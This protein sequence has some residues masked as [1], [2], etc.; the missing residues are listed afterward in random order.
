MLV[1]I[2]TPG[3][4]AASDQIEQLCVRE[5]ADLSILHA[6]QTKKYGSVLC[7]K[8]FNLSQGS[9]IENELVFVVAA[10]LVGVTAT[11]FGPILKINPLVVID[12]VDTF[13]RCA[14]LPMIVDRSKRFML[15]D[16]NDCRPVVEMI[17][18]DMHGWPFKKSELG[19][20]VPSFRRDGAGAQ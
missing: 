20:Q 15:G 1:L 12:F 9:A 10:T 3:S 19:K 16:L 6:Y 8:S 5:A 7:V 14:L 4:S 11:A 18:V 17:L 13:D 2:N